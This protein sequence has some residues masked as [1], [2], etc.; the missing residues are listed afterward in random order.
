[1]LEDRQEYLLEKPVNPSWEGSQILVKRISRL[2]RHRSGP[3]QF[4]SLF[5]FIQL[6]LRQSIFSDG[7]SFFSYLKIFRMNMYQKLIYLC[8]NQMFSVHLG[9]YSCCVKNVFT[10]FK[11]CLYNIQKHVYDIQKIITY[12]KHIFTFSKKTVQC[13]KTDSHNFKNIWYHSQMP[14]AFF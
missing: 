6:L 14:Q 9:K 4:A 7:R 11:K 3:I 10:Q 13:K 8:F 12:C 2:M 1:M 5:V